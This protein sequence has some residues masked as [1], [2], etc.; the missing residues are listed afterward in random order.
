MEKELFSMKIKE[1]RTVDGDFNSRKSNKN[2]R[3]NDSKEDKKLYSLMESVYMVNGIIFTDSFER[4]SENT[5]KHDYLDVEYS[6]LE[7]KE[8]NYIIQ[9]GTFVIVLDTLE[10]FKDVSFDNTKLEEIISKVETS[11]M[12][13]FLYNGSWWIKKEQDFKDIQY[14]R[15]RDENSLVEDLKEMLR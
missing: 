1:R 11:K 14:K 15:V 12:E 4:I 8:K 9:D 2:R 7:T 5:K 13:L 6:V 3:K 10:Y